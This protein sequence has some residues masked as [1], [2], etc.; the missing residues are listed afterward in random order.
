M[1]WYSLYLFQIRFPLIFLRRLAQTVLILFVVVG[2]EPAKAGYPRAGF[3]MST[4]AD[5]T[6]WAERLGAGW[7]LD[8][9]TRDWGTGKAPEYWQM[10][11]ITNGSPRPELDEIRKIARDHPGMVW[12][13][14]NEPDNTLQDNLAAEDYA[15]VFHDV[16]VALKD[17][18]PSAKIAMGAVTQ[19][20]PLRLEYLDRV[21][22]QYQSRY[23][24]KLPVDWWTVHA[25][26][27]REEV[28]SWGAGIPVGIEATSGLLIEPSQH[29]SLDLFYQGLV[30]FRD[31]M[32][33][34]GYQSTP[35][36]VTEFGILLPPSFGY[37]PEVVARY[38][39]GTFQWLD[40]AS[41]PLTGCP[42]DEYRLVQRWAWFSLADETFPV[43]NLVDMS[44]GQLTPAGE[45]FR[46]FT[47]ARARR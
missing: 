20:S 32:K 6:T 19:P 39:E 45:A 29:G 37:S 8:W 23:G 5:P 35:L 15:L 42:T 18:D 43:A 12:V 47:L 30:A 44:S 46:R 3:G 14:G 10:V 36:A 28:N 7:F 21:L 33:E 17:E 2:C 26:V 13:I 16:S 11:R 24:E 27:L 1:V 38:L 31:W 25:Y 40:A 9:G 34:R 4:R 41:D 22:Q